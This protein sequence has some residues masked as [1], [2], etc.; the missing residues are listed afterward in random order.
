MPSFEST[1]RNLYL[2]QR[3]NSESPFI[4]RAEWIACKGD[5]TIDPG[6]NVYVGLDLSG[7][8]DL[9][10]LVLVS[11]GEQDKIKPYFWKPKEGMEEQEKRDRTPYALW[12]KQDYIKTT[13]GK[14]IQ[15]GF[16]AKE[17]AEISKNYNIIGV[18][19][20]RWR[21]NDFYN[22]MAE[23]GLDGYVEGKD[24]MRNGA[25]RLVPWGQGFADM[26]PAIEALETS[27]LNRNF[28]HDGNPCLTWNFANAMTISDPA[29]GRKLDKTKTRF[30]IDGAVATAMAIGLKSRDRLIAQPISAYDKMTKEEIDNSSL[31]W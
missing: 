9:S 26:T 10:A 3:V 1:F 6:S 2:N 23:I 15:F 20:D 14:V 24:D 22:A 27:I 8:I 29:G 17:L 31:S 12:E 18:A 5:A 13:P 16:I 21:I 4:P 7:R 19:F 11:V 25:I 28:V 30:R